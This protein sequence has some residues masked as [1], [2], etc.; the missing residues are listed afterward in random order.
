ML[1][2][3]CALR[4]ILTKQ[5]VGVLVRAALPWALRIAEI[6]RKPCVD[7]QPRVLS[8]LCALVPRQ[9]AAQMFGQRRDRGGDRVTDCF[10]SVPGERGTI[11]DPKLFAVSF[12]ARQMQQHREARRALYQGPDRGAVQTEDEIALPVPGNRAVLGFGRALADHDLWAH[13]LLA[14][15]LRASP[16]DPQCAAGTQACNELTAQRTTALHV[17]RLVDGLV[18]DAHGVIIGEIDAEPF[19][20]LLGAP[21]VGPSSV[22]AT[23]MTATDPAHLRA[24]YGC[25]FGRHDR[26]GETPLHVAPQGV[27]AGELGNL[28][29]AH[30]SICVPLR[31]RSAIL[32]SAASGCS[33]A[34]ELARDRGW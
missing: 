17:K 4:E 2:E 31:S 15:R 14:S 27:V 33:V 3:V 1:A 8:H 30:P 24:G 11:L 7:A 18:G 25:A 19:G 16:R 5:S 32:E 10:S 9:R 34:P 26:A 20:D 13:E 6:D 23:S 22:L 12:H 28:G 21:R 29:A